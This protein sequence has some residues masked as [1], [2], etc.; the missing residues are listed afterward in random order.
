VVDV[1][2]AL[3]ARLGPWLDGA[4][5]TPGSG[6]TPAPARPRV[7]VAR[8]R[9]TRLWLDTPRGRALAKPVLAPNL[10]ER[11][12]V[13]LAPLPGLVLRRDEELFPLD[14]GWV[15]LTWLDPTLRRLDDPLD[16]LA[17]GALYTHAANVA[18]FT[19]ALD[20]DAL[21]D[22]PH[23]HVDRAGL[24]AHPAGRGADVRP[25]A[26][27]AR[28]RLAS[29]WPRAPERFRTGLFHEDLQAGNLLVGPDALH[30]VDL[31]PLWHTYAVM[32][33]A[34]YVAQ[35]VLAK[36]E[37]TLL[38]PLRAACLALLVEESA[39]DFDFFVGVA[40]H[41]ALVRRAFHVDHHTSDWV[42]AY[43]WF[44]DH[45]AVRGYLERLA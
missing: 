12:F 11:A 4:S 16:G 22:G 3:V 19:P 34:H 44:F 32:N 1:L 6:P 31:D 29:R 30:V 7:C 20:L 36:D 43:R 10:G 38:A 25:L 39:E 45:H 15:A 27:H 42:E 24:D 5:T 28:A 26:D 33:L 35:E 18:V 37:P 2:D 17:I 9:P 23:T 40:V 8:D 21:L 41:R 14:D 13:V